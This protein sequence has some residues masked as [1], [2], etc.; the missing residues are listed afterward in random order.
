MGGA[1]SPSF[2]LMEHLNSNRE[3]IKAESELSLKRPA[4]TKNKKALSGSLSK[5]SMA[6][7]SSK[8]AL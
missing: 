1:M 4:T 2:G 6:R 7:K 5:K 8:H 3:S